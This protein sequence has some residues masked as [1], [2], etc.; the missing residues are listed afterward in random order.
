MVNQGFLVQKNPYC[1][2]LRRNLEEFLWFYSIRKREF[3]DNIL[4]V[5]YESFSGEFGIHGS[6]DDGFHADYE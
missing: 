2:W 3:D 6:S 5:E 4:P 1:I